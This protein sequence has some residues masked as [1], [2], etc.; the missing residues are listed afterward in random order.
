MS[1]WPNWVYVIWATFIRINLLYMVIPVRIVNRYTNWESYLIRDI[2]LVSK[3]S[4]ACDTAGSSN[5]QLSANIE[6]S[7]DGRTERTRRVDNT[8]DR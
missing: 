2:N 8:E 4:G 3:T 1:G 7:D 6:K 5:L